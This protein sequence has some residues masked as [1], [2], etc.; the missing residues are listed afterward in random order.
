MTSE[1]ESPTPV[2]S[3]HADPNIPAHRVSGWAIAALLTGVGSATALLH[4]YLWFTAAL[5]LLVASLALIRLQHAA[6]PSSAYRL[7]TTGLVLATVFASWAPTRHYLRQHRLNQ[8]AIAVSQQ[9]LQFLANGQTAKALAAMSDSPTRPEPDDNQPAV[10]GTPAEK[11]RL[12][13]FQQQKL[14]KTLAALGPRA[15]IQHHRS[16]EHIHRDGV[17]QFVNLFA[18]ARSADNQQTTLYVRIRAQRTDNPVTTTGFWRIMNYQ[19]N[20]APR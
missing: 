9:W 13:R 11:N 17:D 19:E 14:V 8:Q 20:V 16:Q 2:F 5:G 10:R 3:D 15:R 6:Q 4:P 1:A 12:Q 7:A 18:V